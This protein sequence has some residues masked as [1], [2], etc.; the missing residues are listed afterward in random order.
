MFVPFNVYF[1]TWKD[2]EEKAKGY[3]N[4]FFTT[5]EWFLNGEL[6]PTLKMWVDEGKKYF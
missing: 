5:P 2:I 6:I 1:I 4:I 3:D